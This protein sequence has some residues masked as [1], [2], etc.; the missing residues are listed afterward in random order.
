MSSVS[1]N[2]WITPHPFASLGKYGEL[3]QK[4]FIGEATDE[5]AK[6]QILPCFY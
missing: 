2:Q 1:G 5:V 6:R 3:D 4:Q